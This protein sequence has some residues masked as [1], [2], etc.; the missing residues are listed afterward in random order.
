MPG[1][2]S[3]VVGGALGPL[4]LY[5]LSK[6]PNEFLW[7]PIEL[8]SVGLGPFIAFAFFAGSIIVGVATKL[9]RIVAPTPQHYWC[10]LE[11]WSKYRLGRIPP[12]QYYEHGAVLDYQRLYCD[13]PPH[14]RPETQAEFVRRVVQWRKTQTTVRKQ[15]ARKRKSKTPLP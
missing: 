8:P 3:I 9:A 4:S 10:L 6:I 2:R 13:I 7:G 5:L 1:A 12:E 14:D 11:V 15:G